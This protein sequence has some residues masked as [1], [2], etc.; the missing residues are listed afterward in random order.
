MRR[1]LAC[2]FW[3]GASPRALAALFLAG[4]CVALSLWGE[5][6]SGKT[7]ESEGESFL[8]WEESKSET[9]SLW[10]RKEWKYQGV[11]EI[12]FVS[13]L[14][15]S[16]SISCHTSVCQKNLQAR[17][18]LITKIS[19][20][21]VRQDLL[22]LQTNKQTLA[23]A[24]EGA[25][26]LL[27][28]MPPPLHGWPHCCRFLDKWNS[29]FV[30]APS[31]TGPPLA[32]VVFVKY[33]LVSHLKVCHGALALQCRTTWNQHSKI[34]K[35]KGFLH[36]YHQTDLIKHEIKIKILP[37]NAISLC[38]SQFHWVN[39]QTPSY[40]MEHISFSVSV[41]VFVTAFWLPCLGEKGEGGEEGC[42][43]YWETPELYGY[44]HLLPGRQSGTRT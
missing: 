3:P 31:N 14:D 40:F 22:F 9:F 44:R 21:Y 35:S 25:A 4:I 23:E 8:I 30:V 12:I 39:L 37:A 10:I 38:L 32:L 19:V 1:G 43:L 15:K 29:K 26:W 7:Q 36:F 33:D 2:L 20:K 28:C 17:K 11:K 18:V 6:E 24:P 5:S 34:S 16:F 41:F 27:L 13:P 42:I